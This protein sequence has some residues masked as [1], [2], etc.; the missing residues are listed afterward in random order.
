MNVEG[1]ILYID[2]F[3]R[4]TE[5]VDFARKQ[6]GCNFFPSGSRL[7]RMIPVDWT[8]TN[9]TSSCYQ[10]LTKGIQFVS[11]CFFIIATT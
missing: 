3:Y 10:K 8:F 9:S 6:F 4:Y 1:N 7:A 2:A 11:A 5:H